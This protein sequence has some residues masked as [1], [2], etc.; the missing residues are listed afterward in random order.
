MEA[1]LID[2]EQALGGRDFY[3]EVRGLLDSGSAADGG[4]A[5][6]RHVGRSRSTLTARRGSHLS[7]HK[8]KPHHATPF[9]TIG[10]A[11]GA[12]GV[13]AARAALPLLPGA[14]RGHQPGKSREDGLIQ[15]WVYVYVVTDDDGGC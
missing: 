5:V 6:D 8:H 9:D 10:D 12:G 2:A 7:L 1:H 15:V 13:P 11:A 3:G 14:R 4:G